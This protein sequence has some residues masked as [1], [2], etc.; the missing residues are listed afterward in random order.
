MR[1]TGPDGYD[2]SE[3]LFPPALWIKALRPN[4]MGLQAY[5]LRRVNSPNETKSCPRCII[6]VQSGMGY[7][8]E[9]KSPGK[10]MPETV[11]PSMAKATDCSMQSKWLLGV[12]WLQPGTSWL[13]FPVKIQFQSPNGFLAAAKIVAQSLF[14]ALEFSLDFLVVV[15][16]VCHFEAC[17]SFLVF[18]H[19]RN[20]PGYRNAGDS[21]APEHRPIHQ[22]KALFDCQAFNRLFGRAVIPFQSTLPKFCQSPQT[23]LALIETIC[24]NARGFANTGF[25]LCSGITQ[26]LLR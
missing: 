21:P 25:T 5:G 2:P 8:L 24:Q 22:N 14:L 13:H 4:V 15:K 17:V 23:R 12:P 11:S 10:P 26:K 9:S 18:K 16:F 6:P 1:N 3:T 7:D 19:V 20:Q